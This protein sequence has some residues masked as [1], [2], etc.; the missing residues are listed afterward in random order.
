MCQD[1]EKMLLEKV[2]KLAGSVAS[3][4]PFL[5]DHL[6]RANDLPQTGE[7]VFSNISHD[8]LIPIAH[9]VPFVFQ[10]RSEHP[11]QKSTP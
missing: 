10:S 7:K 9:R 1:S 2:G 4:G 6:K 5:L 8:D 3:V 11:A